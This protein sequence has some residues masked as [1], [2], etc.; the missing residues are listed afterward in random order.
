MPED[1]LPKPS[2][3]TFAIETAKMIQ[4]ILRQKQFELVNLNFKRKTNKLSDDEF[5]S[6]E[7]D[8]SK[9]IENLRRKL[10]RELNIIQKSGLKD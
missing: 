8:I 2:D 6:L 3:K 9:N 7:K 1:N 10:W 4:E 5:L